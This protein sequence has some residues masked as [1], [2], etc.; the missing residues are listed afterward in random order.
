MAAPEYTHGATLFKAEGISVTLADCP[1]L[2]DLNLEVK[3]IRAKAIHV[4]DSD[5]DR[6]GRACA[7]SETGDLPFCWGGTPNSEITTVL[8]GTNCEPVSGSPFACYLEPTAWGANASRDIGNGAKEVCA[9]ELA[10][11]GNTIR[12]RGTAGVNALDDS[13]DSP[14]TGFQRPGWPPMRALATSRLL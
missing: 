8:P 4:L 13:C 2:R 6:L 3:D 10:D 1:I 5:D 9:L 11:A 7:I 12:C 14:N